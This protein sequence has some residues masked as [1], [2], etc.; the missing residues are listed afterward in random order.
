[1]PPKKTI[2]KSSKKAEP[3]IAEP[4]KSK[5]QAVEDAV[6][7]VGSMDVNRLSCTLRIDTTQAPVYHPGLL[8]RFEHPD[9]EVVKCTMND[10][11][12]FCEEDRENDELSE[13]ELKMVACDGHTPFGP[14]IRFRGCGVDHK[15]SNGKWLTVQE[16]LDAV[17]V[18][19]TATR[20]S[21]EW[22]GGIDTHHVFFEGVW[23][24]GAGYQIG[25][26]S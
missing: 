11:A 12:I 10:P 3:K 4:K 17:G 26:G 24:S 13:E 14:S 21:S 9:T 22:F 15:A 18:H 19:E 20:G 8:N 7:S 16:F 25:W 5:V 23:K 1:M 2:E 6:K